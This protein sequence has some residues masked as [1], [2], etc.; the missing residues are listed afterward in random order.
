MI[1]KIVRACGIPT[2]AVKAISVSGIQI[3]LDSVKTH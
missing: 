1:S 3:R 2:Q